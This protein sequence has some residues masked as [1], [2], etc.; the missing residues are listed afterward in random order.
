MFQNA[1][2]RTITAVRRVPADLGVALVCVIQEVSF[3]TV[4]T[5]AVL[6]N[7]GGCLTGFLT[8]RPARPR[9]SRWLREGGVP[10]QERQRAQ[11]DSSG[12]LPVAH[13]RLNGGCA[14]KL[15]EYTSGGPRLSRSYV[16][17]ASGRNRVESVYYRRWERK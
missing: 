6:S 3:V 14:H 10:G 5:S 2:K 8:P 11:V 17:H 1:T 4:R 9:R 16:Y 12:Q 13:S 7:F 15:V